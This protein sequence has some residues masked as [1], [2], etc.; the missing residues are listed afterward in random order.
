M[1]AFIKNKVSGVSR[2]GDVI[3]MATKD[4]KAFMHLQTDLVCDSR[5]SIT[6]RH[7]KSVLIPAKDKQRLPS[8]VTYKRVSE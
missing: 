8:P 2:D 6:L 7:L 4:K 5:S 1:L 3:G